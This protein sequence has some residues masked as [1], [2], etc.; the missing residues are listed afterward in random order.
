MIRTT[1]YISFI[2]GN[3]INNLYATERNETLRLGLWFHISADISSS[4]IHLFSATRPTQNNFFSPNV[5]PI[6]FY[7]EVQDAEGGAQISP[8]KGVFNDY[9]A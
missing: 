9:L 5:E 2:Y 6:F 1:V 8:L 3:S 7:T 4:G